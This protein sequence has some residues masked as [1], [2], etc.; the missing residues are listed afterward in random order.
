MFSANVSSREGEFPN[1]SG[2]KSQTMEEF[3]L[4]D[5]RT[6]SV[7]TALELKGLEYNFV[8]VLCR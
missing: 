1:S 3:V 7:L 8:L 5:A 2:F 4:R 6:F